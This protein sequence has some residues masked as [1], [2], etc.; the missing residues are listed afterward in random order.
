MRPLVSVVIPCFNRESLIGETLDSVLNQSF[1]NFEVILIDNCST[2]N[3]MMVLNEYSRLDERVKVIQNDRNVGMYPNW[4]VGLEHVQGKYYK[5]LSSDNILHKEFL[6]EAVSIME[7]DESIDLVITSMGQIDINGNDINPSRVYTQ[8][9]Y[10]EREYLLAKSKE[11]FD[12][13]PGA[14]DN[15]LIRTELIKENSIN[16]NAEEFPYSAD[17]DFTLT[18]LLQSK[19]IYT[20]SKSLVFLRIHSDTNTQDSSLNVDRLTELK[21]YQEKFFLNDYEGGLARFTI[22]IVIKL[23]MNGRFFESIQY[24]NKRNE[25]FPNV[26]FRHDLSAGFFLVKEVFLK[27]IRKSSYVYFR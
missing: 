22:F 8:T 6:S 3:T 20:V 15:Q 14:P 27:L 21:R 5:H 23:I 19:K 12:D 4:N 16:Y 17:M 1:E 26:S 2:D 10:I 25:L 7:E 9:G 24:Y 18:C 11:F 13:Y